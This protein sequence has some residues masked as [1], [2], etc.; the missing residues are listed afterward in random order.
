[1]NYEFTDVDRNRSTQDEKMDGRVAVFGEEQCDVGPDESMA[2]VN[3]D[4][5]IE[6]LDDGNRSSQDEKMDGRVAVSAEVQGRYLYFCRDFNVHNNDVVCYEML[7]R[8]Y[9]TERLCN[10]VLTLIWF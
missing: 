9:K 7:Y 2:N 4:V 1:M 10:A 6:P 3:G 8:I 5:Q